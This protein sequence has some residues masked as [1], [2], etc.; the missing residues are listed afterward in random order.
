MGKRNPRPLWQPL[1][2]DLLLAALILALFGFFQIQL[3]A[4]RARDTAAEPLD[5]APEA[6]P[7][8][9]APELTPEPTADIR[10]PWQ[11]RFAEHFRDTPIM[12]DHSYTSPLLSIELQTC[13]RKVLHDRDAVCHIAD[14]YL[15]SPEQFRTYTANNE[16][17]YFSV[18]PVGEMD[19]ASHAVLSI[20]GDCYSFQ[21]SGFLM[22]NGQV[23]LDDQTYCD[24]LVLYEDGRMEALGRGEYRVADIVAAGAVQTWNFGPSLL[25]RDGHA[26]SWFDES[27]AV[28]HPNPRCA[29]GYYEPGHYCFVVVDGRQEESAGMLLPELAQLFED[30]GCQMAYNLDG[31][32]TA[33]MYFN[34]RP[35]SQQ[36]NGADREI[37][38]ILL[39]TE[40]GF[41]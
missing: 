7:A 15:S 27:T 12:T 32:G 35:Y 11:I 3:P 17:A 33:V 10:T 30:L 14:I 34:H 31:G 18:Q 13:V 41:E 4:L 16:L 9:S 22:R 2:A 28:S 5:P 36:S 21:P 26:R 25:D 39:I 6:A 37:G 8:L 1:L 40:E 23:Y 38:D 24:L 20:S 19:A 29:V